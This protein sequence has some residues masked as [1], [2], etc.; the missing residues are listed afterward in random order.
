MKKLVLCIFLGLSWCSVVLANDFEYT[1]KFET[2]FKTS[3]SDNWR[4][5]DTMKLKFYNSGEILKF[6]DY[7]IELEREELEIIINNQ[8]EIVALNIFKDSVNSFVLNKNT[9]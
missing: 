4:N 2:Y 3:D 8:N 5:K 7:E 9:L 1:C 6:Y